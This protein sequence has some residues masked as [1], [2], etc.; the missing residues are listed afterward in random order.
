MLAVVPE[1]G[2]LSP[3][4]VGYTTVGHSGFCRG[5]N[6]KAAAMILL[7]ASALGLATGGCG[8][9]SPKQVAAAVDFQPPTATPPPTALWLN[10]ARVL[11][12]MGRL[13][14]AEQKLWLALRQEPKNPTAQ[15]LLKEV[16]KAE[17]ER[18]RARE[19]PHGSGYLPEQRYW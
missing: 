11:Y 14:D 17:A 5:M 19:W 4:V 7:G 13:D 10:E 1:N 12:E 18:T 8:T 2:R 15:E 6:I 9:S 3:C 16:L